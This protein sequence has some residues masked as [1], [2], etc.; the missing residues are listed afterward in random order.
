MFFLFMFILLLL[1]NSDVIVGLLTPPQNE[2]QG[3]SIAAR[4][5]DEVMTHEESGSRLE[6]RELSTYMRFPACF[7]PD[8]EGL[9]CF[10]V[11]AY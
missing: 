9:V 7:Y 11:H 6:G 3:R 10:S 5:R 1:C 8:Q 4:L 2:N